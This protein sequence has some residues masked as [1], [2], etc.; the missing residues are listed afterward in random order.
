M[1]VNI[2]SVPDRVFVPNW[3]SVWSY[4][5]FLG[6]RSDFKE[7]LSMTKSISIVTVYKKNYN[8]RLI[9]TI[10][11]DPQT[12]Y[13]LSKRTNINMVLFNEISLAM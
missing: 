10:M 8:P 9:V 5:K 1:G 6:R 12:N 7:L 3:V 13:T 11:W 2:I 4:F